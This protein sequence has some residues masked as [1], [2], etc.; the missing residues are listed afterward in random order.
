MIKADPG[1]KA[2]FEYRGGVEDV[3][4]VA[5]SDEGVPLVVHADTGHLIPVSEVRDKGT[6][7]RVV[8]KHVRATVPGDGWEVKLKTSG[9]GR[10]SW[11]TLPVL[12]F[13]FYD[14]GDVAATVSE[15]GQPRSVRLG[16]ATR[17]VEPDA[18]DA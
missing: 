13:H 9:R 6:F 5:W 17:L 18:E 3:P 2:R 14:G 7:R 4:I 11:Y 16:D 1:W 8:C 10:D 15:D 12:A